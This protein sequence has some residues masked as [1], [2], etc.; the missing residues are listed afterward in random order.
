MRI[1]IR[2]LAALLLAVAFLAGCNG[3]KI[4][5]SITVNNNPNLLT[6]SGK[7]FSNTNHCAQLSLLGLPPPEAVVSL[8]MPQ[9]NNGA[10]QSFP[11][12]YAA[13]N[14][15]LNGTQKTVVVAV[16]LSTQATASQ[17]ISIPW[18]PGCSLAGAC[19]VGQQSDTLCAANVCNDG[20]CQSGVIT[21]CANPNAPTC[22]N[23]CANHGGVNSSLGCVQE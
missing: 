10:F 17:P 11:W 14:C 18:G 20:S 3:G 13:N 5:P 1:A 2:T 15:R 12:Q 9:C 22:T 8:G 6:I 21:S 16:D 23:G 4:A 19:T 7:N